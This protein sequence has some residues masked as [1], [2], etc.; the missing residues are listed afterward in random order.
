[1]IF[2]LEDNFAPEFRC[3]RCGAISR[4]VVAHNNLHAGEKRRHTIERSTSSHDAFVQAARLIE[5]WNHHGEFVCHGSFVALG[6]VE[7]LRCARNPSGAGSV[8][9]GAQGISA[10]MQYYLLLTSIRILF[11]NTPA[12]PNNGN[13]VSTSYLLGG[14]PREFKLCSRALHDNSRFGR[15]FDAMA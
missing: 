2:G 13:Q 7:S 4:V 14:R 5:G 9:L 10:I 12:L 11:K 1:L 3:D 8:L 15:L 6:S